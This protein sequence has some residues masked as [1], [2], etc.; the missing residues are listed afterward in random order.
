MS[1]WLVYGSDNLYSHWKNV[2]AEYIEGNLLNEA[3]QEDGKPKK[4]DK[5][6]ANMFH[7]FD[8]GIEE[9]TIMKI[10]DMIL[11]GSYLIKKSSSYRGPMPSMEQLAQD[12]KVFK[13]LQ[14]QVLKY[15]KAKHLHFFVACDNWEGIIEKLP[16]STE[17]T[18]RRR[19][20]S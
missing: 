17:E 10:L 16:S 15:L 13:A 12:A 8:G 18:T 2:C 14:L 20:L 9:E 4:V 5:V 1:N 11:D 7:C 19:L 3:R 6:T